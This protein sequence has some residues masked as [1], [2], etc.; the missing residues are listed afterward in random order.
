MHIINARFGVDGKIINKELYEKLELKSSERVI[1]KLL[2][3]QNDEYKVI[4]IN[5]NNS[6]M[7]EINLIN[8]DE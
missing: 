3:T 4:D 8:E 1:C 5:E 2:E 6:E 7:N